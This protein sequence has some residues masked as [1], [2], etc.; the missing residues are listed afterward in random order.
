MVAADAAGALDETQ[1]VELKQA[2]PAANKPAN[3]ELA[4]D[5]ASLS[6]DGGVLVI[7]IADAGGA[8]GDVVGVDLS[9]LE[10]RVA[11][12]A[13]A[14]ISP[15]L[16]V[17]FDVFDK[18]G[19]PG[20][21]VA[22]VTVPASEGAPHMVD[23]SYWGRSA[24]GKRM[25]ADD[26][27]RRLLGDR[28][29]RAAGFIDRLRQAPARLDPPDLGGLG[30]MYVV[31]EPATAAPEPM[32]DL[33]EDQHLLHVVMPAIGFRPRLSPSLTSA[34]V[35]VPHPDGLAT[36][37]TALEYAGQEPQQFLLVLLTDDGTVHLSAPAVRTYGQRPGAP[38]V[39]SPAL[40]LELLHS[41][42]AATGQVAED[43]TGYQG[44]WR[45]GLLVTGLR[46]L[47]P[48]QAHS[49]AGFQRFVPYPA[50]D[51]VKV[52]QATTRQ[53]VEQTPTVVERL[54][55]GLLRGLGVD[56]RFLPYTDPS[57]IAARI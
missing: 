19:E 20:V 7:G 40:V 57:E 56:R 44:L 45:I 42:V 39:V 55:K 46:G 47:V 6:V 43:H 13:A 21:G 29:A 48:T 41:V 10:S 24:H 52:E 11:Q 27:V 26:E 38:N 3:L 34:G 31:L 2:V 5:L 54:V 33:L 22:I 28:Q 4:R 1:W 8:A 35:W 14:R 53:L 32:S 18:P 36:A 17:A 23:G 15:P 30:R 50:E 16:P 12:V 25:L 9:G 49:E 37:S 51:Y